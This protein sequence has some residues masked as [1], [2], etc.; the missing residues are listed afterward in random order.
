MNE[1]QINADKDYDEIKQ[2]VRSLFNKDPETDF[3]ARMRLSFQVG[4][5]KAKLLELH[6]RLLEK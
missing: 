6:Q 4:C 5:L 1:A 3:A 2:I